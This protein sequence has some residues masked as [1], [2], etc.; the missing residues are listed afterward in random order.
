MRCET[1]LTP[2]REWRSAGIKSERENG[3]SKMEISQW[4]FSSSGWKPNGKSE[5]WKAS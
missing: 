1:S 2:L 3:G 5:C 4:V